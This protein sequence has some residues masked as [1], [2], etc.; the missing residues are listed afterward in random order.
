MAEGWS[1]RPTVFA[2]A[3][4]RFDCPASGLSMVG[5]LTPVNGKSLIPPTRI[6]QGELLIGRG[7]HADGVHLQVADEN[8]SRLHARI[9]RTGNRFI[10]DDAN[11]SN[12]TFLDGVPIRSALLHDGD[13][14][15]IGKSLAYFSHL[16]E[17]DHS[18]QIDATNDWTMADRFAR[19]RLIDEAAG[20]SLR[21][22]GT[23][24]SLPTPGAETRKYGGNT[25][26]LELRFGDTI[27][28]LDAGSGIREMSQAWAEEF[29]Q[30]AIRANL[31][32]T[33]LHWDHIQGFPFFGAAYQAKNTIHIYG[34]HREAGSTKELLSA[35]MRGDY[36]PVPLSTMQ[37]SMDFYETSREFSIDE[38]AI[39]TF[40]LP[41][42]NG[43][44][45]YRF[46]AG[47]AV[48]V[49][50]TDSELDQ[51]AA[52]GSQLNQDFLTPRAYDPAFMEPFRGADLL[53]VDCQYSDEE[54]RSR[55]G[56]GHNSIATVVDL[57]T[58]VR[59]KMVALTH[60]DP[61]SNDW[62]VA[63][64][65]KEVCDRL[66]ASGVHDVL[67]FGAREQLTISVQTP[68]HPQETFS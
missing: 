42:P 24:G 66:Q 43:S 32:L 29:Q 68:K 45:G 3:S 54:Y 11:S 16:Y 49:M 27:I 31:C 2:A 1:T 56:W 47:G 36:F 48:F 21:F 50:A 59:P 58:Q 5:V 7:Q 14:I 25:T 10:L 53:V 30:Q 23:R 44:L 60:H 19:P 52:N 28:V 9:T 34:A 39:E 13:T 15:Q 51:I 6:D 46:A 17:Y 40:D 12:G 33:H 35:Q 38:V 8:V 64:R 41:H 61:T 20:M 37:S 67:V 18:L 65:V 4:E 63:E 62:S 57:C 26:C 22:W 55:V